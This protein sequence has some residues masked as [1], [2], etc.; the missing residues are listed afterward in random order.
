MGGKV[1]A[2]SQLG[3]GSKYI[4][5]LQ[6][7]ITDSILNFSDNFSN[8]MEKMQIFEDRGAFDFTPDFNRKF[9]IY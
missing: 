1:E 6:L 8:T 9:E 4:I 3:R 7:R 5:T 2:S